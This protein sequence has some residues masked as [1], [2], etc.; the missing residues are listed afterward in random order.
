MKIFKCKSPS[1]E[2][3]FTIKVAVIGCCSSNGLQIELRNFLLEKKKRFLM[4]KRERQRE[5]QV[6]NTAETSS[7]FETGRE[8]E[9]EK[10][11]ENEKDRE[12]DKR[13]KTMI[14]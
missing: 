13:R 9:R 11:N 5:Y 14:Q 1:N 10:E 7:M 4:R 6:E 12:R 2:V 8:S 3:V